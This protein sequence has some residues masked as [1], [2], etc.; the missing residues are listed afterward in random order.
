[1]LTPTPH[2]NWLC[3]IDTV[4]HEHNKNACKIIKNNKNINE[5]VILL[6]VWLNQQQLNKGKGALLNHLFINFVIQLLESQILNNKMSGYQIFR[7]VIL[8]ITRQDWISNT[9]LKGSVD[10]TEFYD[11]VLQDQSGI[12]NLAAN[13]N[14]Q[15]YQ[16]VSNKCLLPFLL[17]IL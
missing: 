4:M 8:E 10:H 6:K 16:Q 13:M 3:A 12:F 14:T 7:T 17:I 1:M 2:Y 11:V 15:F 9:K 5:G